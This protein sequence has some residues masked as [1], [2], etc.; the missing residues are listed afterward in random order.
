MYKYQVMNHYQ[1]TRCSNMR[2]IEPTIAPNSAWNQITEGIKAQRAEKNLYVTATEAKLLIAGLELVLSYNDDPEE[3]R[4][5]NNLVSLLK[6][7]K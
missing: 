7:I 3:C 2:F 4:L 6:E 5:C 1:T